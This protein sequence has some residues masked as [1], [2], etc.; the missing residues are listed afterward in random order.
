MFLGLKYVKS[1]NQLPF[2]YKDLQIIERQ[3]VKE[4][5]ETEKGVL[6]CLAV[7]CTVIHCS[8][9]AEWVV[10][11]Y[12][13][14]TNDQGWVTATKA[15]ALAVRCLSQNNVF[16]S[17]PNVLWKWELRCIWSLDGQPT[18][19][20]FNDPAPSHK[21]F[22]HLGFV[23]FSKQERGAASWMCNQPTKS[24]IIFNGS[25]SPSHKGS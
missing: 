15:W 8:G 6:Q 12:C 17:F 23:Q 7:S 9:F 14:I 25:S 21:M 1:Q 2:S 18:K 4:I 13:G 5:W 3:N 11:G 24:Q 19:I 22:G 20:C 16:F 10:G